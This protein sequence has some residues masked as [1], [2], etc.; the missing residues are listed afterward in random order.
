[1]HMEYAV[2]VRRYLA[3]VLGLATACSG[4]G[5]STG[6]AADAA[7]DGTVEASGPT[8]ATSGGTA[9]DGKGTDAASDVSTAAEAGI[10]IS[11]GGFHSCFM[12][13]GMAKCWGSNF[14]GE[15]GNGN[16]VPTSSPTPTVVIG[17][18]GGV[19][20]G[21]WHA[22]GF[23]GT[24]VDCWG[25]NSDDEL[26]H[27]Q[28]RELD[29]GNGDASDATAGIWFSRPSTSVP[30]PAGEL[31]GTAGLALGYEYSCALSDQ[32]AVSCWG[33]EL[34]GVLGDSPAE[35]GLVCTGPT[36]GPCS[37][38]PLPIPT[39]TAG[40]SEISA[41]EAPTVCALKAADGSVW[42]WGHNEYGELG[43]SV[44]DGGAAVDSDPHT[45]PVA[46][47]GLLNVRR[48]ASG[49]IF[50]CAILSDATVSCWGS[51]ATGALGRDPA[52]DPACSAS[53]CAEPPA[54]VAGLSNVR[55]LGLGEGFACALLED[56]TVTCWGQ[57]GYGQLGH[58]PATDSDSGAAGTFKPHPVPGLSNVAHIASGGG[59]TCALER[60][61]TV[62]CWGDNGS[63]ELGPGVDAGSTFVPTVVSGL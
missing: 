62:L 25:A 3:G 35:G 4:N 59:H 24:Q 15:L 26:G 10:G 29:A 21:V 22:C 27:D 28:G 44:A 19:T 16:H 30:T 63:G 23:A 57:N 36:G 50:R 53:M 17:V 45:M 34:S 48:I 12:S 20:H 58:D 55:E 47:P 18:T 40:V 9:L 61:N 41:S 43:Q 39:L 32:G 5:A 14:F 49:D 46:V 8:D 37:P 52:A 1:M 54:V 38:T 11:A 7:T 13:G 2:G 42:C 31:G 51:N 56:D 6:S 33:A 60:D